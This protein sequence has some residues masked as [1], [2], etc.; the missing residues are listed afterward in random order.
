MCFIQLLE[1]TFK[2]NSKYTIKLY[3]SMGNLIA[4]K[5]KRKLRF[6]D[7]TAESSCINIELGLLLK[8][9]IPIHFRLEL[10]TGKI[11]QGE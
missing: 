8:C 5:N 10:I 11:V 1:I 4:N 7:Q 2:T 6:L 9:V 3:E